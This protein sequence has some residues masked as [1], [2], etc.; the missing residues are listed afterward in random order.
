MKK[1]LFFAA[2]FAVMCVGFSSCE[3]ENGKDGGGSLVGEWN[4]AEEHVTFTFTSDG[5]WSV[6]DYKYEREED[7]GTYTYDKKAGTIYL[8]YVPEIGE[9][10]WGRRWEL[11]NDIS[12]TLKA[13]VYDEDGYQGTMTLTRKK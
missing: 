11:R 12:S 13:E 7:R 9:P 6:Y 3:K 4:W 2:L 10:I 5:K 8:T 1:Y